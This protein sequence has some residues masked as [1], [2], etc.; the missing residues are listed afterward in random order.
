MGIEYGMGLGIAGA[1]WIGI[2]FVALI[3][4]ASSLFLGFCIYYDA[5]YRRVENAVMWAVLS[6]LFNILALVYLI[7][8]VTKSPQPLR[9]FQCGDFLLPNSRFCQRCGRPINSPSLE[10]LEVYSKKRKLFFWIWI[11]SLALVVVLSTLFVAL[12]IGSIRFYY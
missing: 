11:S 2:V 1:I 6:G 7:V 12:I 5:L 3:G 4:M 8:Y 9:C 10:Q